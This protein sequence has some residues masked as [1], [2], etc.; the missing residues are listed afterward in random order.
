MRMA[1]VVLALAI[2]RVAA[3]APS[4]EV[5]PTTVDFGGTIIGRVALE[6]LTLR[7]VGDQPLIFGAPAV[8]SP[9]F[10]LG[11]PDGGLDP[12]TSIPAG[13]SLAVGV[14]FRPE[15]GDTLNATLTLPSNDP[16][17]PEFEVPLSGHGG[18]SP[19]IGVS[20][21]SFSP[22]LDFGD[23]TS[24]PLE[25]RNTG[26]L[27][28]EWTLSAL[29]D[30]GL[31]T[32]LAGVRVLWDRTHNGQSA[33]S[34]SEFVGELEAGGAIVE[35]RLSGAINA[36]ALA[37]YRLYVAAEPTIAWA[38]A[39]RAALAEWCALGGGILLMGDSG[40]SSGHF[41]ALLSELSSG[42]VY[43][44]E[45]TLGDVSVTSSG[46]SSHP[47]TAGISRLYVGTQARKLSPLSAPASG[48]VRAQTDFPI[49]AAADLGIGR[50]AA[51]GEELFD[52]VVLATAEGL[53]TP[54]QNRAFGVQLVDWLAGGLWVRPDLA[55]GTTAPG[56]TST[57]SLFF[58]SADL[59]G[60]TL[61]ATLVVAS[62]D[63]ANPEVDVPVTLTIIGAPEIDVMPAT[64]DF[65]PVPEE[66]AGS[67]TLVVKN[68]GSEQLDVSGVSVDDPAFFADASPFSLAPGDSQFVEIS[69]QPDAIGA[70]TG[71]VTFSSNAANDSALAVPVA[72]DGIVNCSLPCGSSSL[73]AGDIDGAIGFE[74]WLTVDV[75]DTPAPIQSFGFE[76]NYDAAHLEYRGAVQ[77]G[78]LGSF[79]PIAQENEPGRLSCGG[80]GASIPA[81]STGPLVRLLFAVVCDTC[82]EGTQSE[83]TVTDLVEDVAALRPCC[84]TL[85]I[86]ACPSGHGDV[87]LDDVLG[88]TDALCALRIWANGGNPVPD[89]ECQAN[90]DCEAEAADVTCDGV[91]TPGDAQAI[92][93][94]VL[95][96]ADPFPVPCFGQGDPDPCGSLRAVGETAVRW[97]APERDGDLWR[98]PVVAA[99]EAP[100]AFG[101]ELAMDGGAE[102]IAAE[103][104]PSASGWL[105]AQASPAAGLARVGAVRPTAFETAPPAAGETILVLTVRAPGPGAVSVV[106]AVESVFR[107]PAVADGTPGGL[108][109]EGI[110]ALRPNPVRDRLEI[111]LAAAPGRSPR[112]LRIVDVAG[113]RVRALD[114]GTEPR[115]VVV[116]DGRDD[117]GRPT[118][119]GVYFVVLRRDDDLWTRKVLRVR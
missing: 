32:R 103:P 29:P 86:A 18:S 111:E 94:R 13:D 27:D 71:T 82:P 72:G 101:L 116:W 56:D 66:T 47:S 112:T 45:T 98:L 64:L 35:E 80:F 54:G 43:S 78:D 10:S 88:G 91:V 77:A 52:N 19:V 30:A 79:N 81:G 3:A 49:V 21:A 96:V 115:T 60:T 39:E 69:F 110:R 40:P 83:I 105:L 57:V 31:R 53:S 92:Y 38:A 23:T 89:E 14:A 12:G 87:N 107:G 97:G 9:Y 36:A 25:I 51:L 37:P 62:N 76:L 70:F 109:R 84:G 106:E 102:I 22:V 41:N 4:L 26:D 34:W 33:L 99:S 2:A 59:A 28:L 100:S 5:S 63:V 75:S 20:P 74:F 104:D 95:C 68:P 15:T 42:I 7:N 48:L 73:S 118:A 46:I 93:E 44:L 61:H 6:T 50:V 117:E 17:Q 16:A 11:G 58:D 108:V 85:T 1:A 24:L 119:S 67:D 8:D 55:S 90:G 114:P 113:R 65:G